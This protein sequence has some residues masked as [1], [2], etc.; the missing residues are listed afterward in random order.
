MEKTEEKL[1][2]WENR[3]LTSFSSAEEYLTVNEI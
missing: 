2:K 1:K 3:L